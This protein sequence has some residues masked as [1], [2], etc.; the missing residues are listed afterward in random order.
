MAAATAVVAGRG[1]T[2]AVVSAAGLACVVTRPRCCSCRRCCS[3]HRRWFLPPLAFFASDGIVA[4][5][6][7]TFAGSAIRRGRA[8]SGAFAA[9]SAAF[10]GR[11]R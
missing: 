11:R 5:F 10:A 7:D 8:A 6:A 1:S 4:R 3:R 9:A 2:F